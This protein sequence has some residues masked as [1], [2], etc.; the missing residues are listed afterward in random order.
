[1][2]VGFEPTSSDYEPDKL[3]CYS[4]SSLNKFSEEKDLNL[5]SSV[6]K[7]EA[8]ARLCYL[9]FN[10]L[11]INNDGRIRTYNI[12]IMIPILYH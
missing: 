3:T 9:P 7:T 10:I 8:L 4:I 11:N 12:R 1:M 5:W 2:R 6:P